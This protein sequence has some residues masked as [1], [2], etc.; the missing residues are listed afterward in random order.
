MKTTNSK[1]FLAITS[2]FNQQ[3]LKLEPTSK[4]SQDHRHGGDGEA[5]IKKAADLNRSQKEIRNQDW[6]GEDAV[7]P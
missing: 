5:T 7:T 3:G 6:H 2:E 1:P 4:Q